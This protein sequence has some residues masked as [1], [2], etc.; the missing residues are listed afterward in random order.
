VLG[1]LAAGKMAKAPPASA[2]GETAVDGGTVGANPVREPLGKA[3][4]LEI[5]PV[6]QEMPSPLLE[7]PAGSIA[8]EA[9]KVISPTEPISS[10][11]IGA[12]P[13]P[14]ILGSQNPSKLPRRQSPRETSEIAT[15]R[16]SLQ[17]K[18]AD[19]AL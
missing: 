16:R 13:T 3:D 8:P 1:A 10:A 11:D 19:Q 17:A 14:R 4:R 12:N 18:R 2:M 9:Q 5:T 15:H 7:A 6:R